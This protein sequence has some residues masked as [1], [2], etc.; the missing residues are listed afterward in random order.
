MISFLIGF[1]IMPALVGVVLVITWAVEYFQ[2]VAALLK[3]HYANKYAI[4]QAKKVIVDE[5]LSDNNE[6]EEINANTEET[7]VANENAQG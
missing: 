3:A 6:P 7:P 1:M 4:K 2:Y 5:L